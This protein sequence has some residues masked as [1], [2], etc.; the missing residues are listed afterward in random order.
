MDSN[1]GSGATQSR[2][3]IQE[4][5]GMLVRGEFPDNYDQIIREI[6]DED[7]ERVWQVFYELRNDGAA[8]QVADSPAMS[9]PR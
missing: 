6:S 8:N 1:S 5:A 9:N 3:S 2:L 7:L 4:L